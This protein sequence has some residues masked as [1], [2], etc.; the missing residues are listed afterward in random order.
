MN[1]PV[2]SYDWFNRFVLY[3]LWTTAICIFITC[4]NFLVGKLHFLM[5]LYPA[6]KLDASKT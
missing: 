5:G 3:T 1:G 4:I 2:G 6:N